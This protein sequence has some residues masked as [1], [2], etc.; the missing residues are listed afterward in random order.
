MARGR[1]GPGRQTGGGR[2]QK[3]VDRRP[4]ELLVSSRT[5]FQRGA[6]HGS[7]GLDPTRSVGQLPGQH[8]ERLLE[9]WLMYGAELFVVWSYDTPLAWWV[10]GLGGGGGGW[11]VPDVSYRSAKTTEHQ[12]K[13]GM[14]S[15]VAV[16]PG[17]MIP[18]GGL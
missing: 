10:P 8:R 9:D 17:W 18:Q 3:V 14:V 7:E 15:P 1:S 12:S 5:A 2:K 13:L 6:F 16:S 11:R 4:V